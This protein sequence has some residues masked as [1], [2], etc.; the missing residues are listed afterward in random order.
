MTAPDHPHRGQVTVSY[1]LQGSTQ[2]L[3]SYGHKGDLHPGDCQWQRT[4]TFRSKLNIRKH[5]CQYAHMDTYQFIWTHSVG[6][7]YLFSELYSDK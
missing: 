6:E 4:S 1:L 7:E 5:G 2:H 3:D